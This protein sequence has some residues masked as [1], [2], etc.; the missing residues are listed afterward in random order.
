[1]CYGDSTVGAAAAYAAVVALLYR[2][3]SGAGQFVDV[4]A[5]ETLSSMIGDRLLEHSLTGECLGSDRNDHPVMCPHSCY[6]CSGGSWVSLAVG[7]AEEWQR[8]CDVL[9]ATALASATRR[10]GIDALI[11][12]RSTTS[13][14]ASLE[15]GMPSSS[16]APAGGGCGRE[17]QRDRRRRDRRP[18]I[19]GARVVPI[20]HRSPRRPTSDIGTIV[21]DSASPARIERGAPDLG[22]DNDYV[23]HEILAAGSP[24]GGR[25]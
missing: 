13:L 11:A 10:W 5:V 6:P 16:R 9:G 25:K 14:R 23:L 7:N 17:Q 21:A 18:T 1:M 24:T 12:R 22:Q 20:R 4:S 19:V 3:V 2:E 15:T 8:L